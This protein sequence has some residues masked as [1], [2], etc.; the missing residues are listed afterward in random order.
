MLSRM[1]AR[2]PHTLK[3]IL[4]V[5]FV[6]AFFTM[7]QNQWIQVSDLFV[8]V[9]PLVYAYSISRDKW[10]VPIFWTIVLTTFFSA[11]ASLCLHVFSSLKV[12][13]PQGFSESTWYQVVLSVVANAVLF[14][15]LYLVSKLKKNYSTPNW[16]VLT[17]F[18][19]TNVVIFCVEEALYTMQIHMTNAQETFGAGFVIAYI[20]LIMCTV[21]F[22]LLFHV[23][24]KTMD[25]EKYYRIQAETLKKDAQYQQEIKNMYMSM[26]AMR[27]DFKHHFDTLSEMVHQGKNTEAKQYLDAYKKSVEETERFVT[28]FSALDALL[29]TK[30]LSMKQ[31]D[32]HFKCSKYPLDYLPMQDSEFCSVLGNALDN[33]MEGV[34]RVTDKKIK[35]NVTLSFSLSWDMLYIYC[36]NPCNETT[37]SLNEKEQT[38][39]SSKQ[40]HLQPH[41]LGTM[42]IQKKVS[43]VGGTVLF[44]VKEGVFLI[45]IGIPA[46]NAREGAVR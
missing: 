16:A 41:A 23:M 10:Y 7:Q 45:K 4:C 34:Q 12:Y 2:K 5:C 8:F 38:F 15:V 35:R 32:I 21:F 9:I 17:L 6:F 18:L 33:A 31:Q 46:L 22:I 11:I 27:H 28:G 25:N 43:K 40:D 26:C 30:S 42:N 36:S 1:H 19:L 37:I 44:S 3:D 13:F 39:K 20:G 24:S 29:T 14:L